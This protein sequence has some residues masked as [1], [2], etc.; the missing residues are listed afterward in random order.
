MR[1][2]FESPY[3]TNILLLCGVFMLVRIVKLLSSIS[4]AQRNI[5]DLARMAR[6]AADHGESMERMTARLAE[7]HE[8]SDEK[9]YE[10]KGLQEAIIRKMP[11]GRHD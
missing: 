1:E 3:I 5:E 10:I 7:S 2:L 9:L 8:R 6:L 4:Q 11:G